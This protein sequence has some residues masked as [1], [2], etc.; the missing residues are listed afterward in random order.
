M[1]LYIACSFYRSRS[2]LLGDIED[3]DDAVSA[4]D[5]E[6]FAAIAE[7]GRE[8]GTG[9]VVDAV[10]RLE[11]AIAVE[12]FDF[13]RSRT[14]CQD[15]VIGVLL[16]LRRVQLHWRARRQFLIEWNVLSQVTRAQVPEL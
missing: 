1:S 11:E 6:H 15:Q 14:A 8:A 4:T 5:R 7:I 16:E 13:V 12:N 10:A 2:S 3:A 9:Q